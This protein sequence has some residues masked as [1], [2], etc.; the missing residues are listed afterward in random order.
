MSGPESDLYFTELSANQIGR[1]DTSGNITAE[2]AIPTSNAGPAGI[3]VGPDGHLWFTE[4]NGDRVGRLN[5]EPDAQDDGASVRENQ[6]LM[7]R[8]RDP[9]SW[10]TIPTPKRTPF[11]PCSSRARR[12]A[13][14]NLNSDGSFTYTPDPGYFGDDSFQ[15]AARDGSSA[16]S[17]ATV[18]LTVIPDQSADGE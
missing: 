11:P 8:C 17:T 7:P 13:R 6:T 4:Q 5:L 12:T 16:G 15:Y 18:S 3:A 1:I 9:A 14:L 10:P 2:Y